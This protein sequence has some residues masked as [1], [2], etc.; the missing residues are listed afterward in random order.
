M[1]TFATWNASD[2]DG[3][4]T[5]S[6]G[7]L[8]ATAAAIGSWQAARSTIGVSSGKWY[9]EYTINAVDANRDQ[10]QGIA[11]SSADLAAADFGGGQGSA[12]NCYV[13]YGFNGTKLNGNSSAAYGNTYTTNDVVD[14][15]LDLDNGKIFFG[16]NGTWQNSG[17][18]VAGTNAAY[19]GVSGTYFAAC[20]FNQGTQALT[21]NFGAT[22]FANTVPTGFN[23]GLYTGSLTTNH[24]LLLAGVG[25]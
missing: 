12:G 17:D 24:F 16:K 19:T 21:A 5:L 6:N 20:S 22:A 15:A 8:K 18:P 3:D 9:W 13:Y 10:E 4:I 14:V 25:A 11:L 23:P 1:A 7:N 2:K